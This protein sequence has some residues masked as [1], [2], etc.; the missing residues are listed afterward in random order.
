MTLTDPAGRPAAEHR[1]EALPTIHDADSDAWNRL[2]RLAS[3]SVFH[4]WEWL[5]AFEDAPPGAF[6]PRHLAAFR[7]DELVGICP[8]YLVHDCPR[9]SYLM[10]LGEFAPT[11]PV[12]LAHSLAALDGGPLAA[13]GHAPAVDALL[14]AL[15]ETARSAGARVWGVA[16]AP[17]DRLGGRLMRHGYATA[18][19]TTSYRCATD[20]PSVQEYWAFAEGHRR[21]KLARERRIAGRDH[22]VLD[23]PADTDTLVRLVHSLLR[24]R[25]T[26]TDVLPGPFLRAMRTRLAPFE[27]SITAADPAGATVGVF[28]GWQFGPLWSMWLAGLDTA[29][30][31]SFVPYRAMGGRLVESA[32]ATDVTTVDLGRSNGMEKRKLGA[33]PVP[34]HLALRTSGRGEQA[35]LHASC[36]RLEQ[37]CQGPEEQLDL[38]RRC[39]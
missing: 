8:A 23:E 4:S 27:R 24:D 5:A 30:L 7:G 36:L 18:H 35:A 28:A 2:V 21:R 12:L 19:I 6:E 11:G 16:N 3:G 39:C 34:L 14:R 31:P 1:I 29:L 37:R 10:E 17:A 15:G 38:T 20:A 22:T 33:H 26:P 32:V 13:P 25:D 9:L